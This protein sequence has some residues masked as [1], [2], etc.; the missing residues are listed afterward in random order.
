MITVSDPVPSIESPSSITVLSEQ[1]KRDFCAELLQRYGLQLHLDNELLPVLYLAY[2]AAVISETSSRQTSECLTR[3]TRDLER[4]SPLPPNPVITKPV[5][6]QSTRQAFWLG[7]GGVGLPL[8]V[9]LLLGTFVWWFYQYQSRI[10]QD[11]SYLEYLIEHAGV[12]DFVVN[13]TTLAKVIRLH[14]AVDLP[15]ARAGQH[16][17]Y[18][19]SNKCVIIPLFYQKRN[20]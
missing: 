5:Q 8:I 1:Q 6:L 20:E 19:A 15:Q 10:Q 14:P 2:R 18:D 3:V 17:V 4:K 7:F 11:N 16:Y 13:D 9:A 12:E